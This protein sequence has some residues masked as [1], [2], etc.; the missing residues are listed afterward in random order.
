MKNKFPEATT[1]SE[2]KKNLNDLSKEKIRYIDILIQIFI[3]APD[4]TEEE[5][6]KNIFISIF[7]TILESL[8][9]LIGNLF[10]LKK[11]TIDN[12][13]VPSILFGDLLLLNLLMI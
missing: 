1:V 2:V 4:K 6:I 12:T 10:A 3:Y 5:K 13:S 9:K 7:S 8:V 11:I